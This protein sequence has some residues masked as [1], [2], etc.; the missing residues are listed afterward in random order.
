[1]ATKVS[2]LVTEVCV[3]KAVLGLAAAGLVLSA[4][5]VAFASPVEGKIPKLEPQGAKFS[6]GTYKFNRPGVNH[7]A[8][9]WWGELKDV[10]A[11]DRH[12][13]YVEVKVEGHDWVRYYGKQRSTVHLHKSNW[14][15][16][17]R[18]TSRAHIRVCRDQGALRPDNCA[19]VQDY[20]YNWDRG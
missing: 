20:E 4:A 7:G 14:D 17:Q 9:E 6:Q 15:G 16:A 5:A 18:Y 10:I 12:N 1:M 11:T 2:L 8:F 13:V 3:K 19:P